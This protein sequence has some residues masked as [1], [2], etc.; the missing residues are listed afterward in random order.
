MEVQACTLQTLL[1]FSCKCSKC[2]FHTER[3]AC[4]DFFWILPV[5]RKCLS[6]YPGSIKK[7]KRWDTQLGTILWY[8]L[9][10]YVHMLT[11]CCRNCFTPENLAFFIHLHIG[12]FKLDVSELRPVTWQDPNGLWRELK[13]SICFDSL[14]IQI[15][16]LVLL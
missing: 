16:K 14:I 5:S 9:T 6:Y 10:V 2:A 1:H 13:I 7:R 3:L 11:F 12:W 8:R 15:A 4:W